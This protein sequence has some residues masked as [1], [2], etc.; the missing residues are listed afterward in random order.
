MKA[1]DSEEKGWHYNVISQMSILRPM[2]WVVGRL[3]SIINAI[4]LSNRLPYRAIHK[5]FIKWW[6][7]AKTVCK[8]N[9]CNKVSPPIKHEGRIII[10]SS[11]KCDIYN[12]YFADISNI[13][14]EPKW[15]RWCCTQDLT[16]CFSVH[17]FLS[18]LLHYYLISHCNVDNFH[19]FGNAHT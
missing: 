3:G 7:I 14:I 13:E 10:H 9:K 12:K 4:S 17:C 16:Q 1:G 18:P 15:S 5:R 19:I 11:E 2:I 6:R 8:L